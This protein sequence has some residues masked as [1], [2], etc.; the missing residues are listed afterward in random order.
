VVSGHP[1]CSA[2][3]EHGVTGIVL[4]V[5]PSVVEIATAVEALASD[6]AKAHAM[7]AAARDRISTTFSLDVV[8]TRLLQWKAVGAVRS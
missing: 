8:L 7:G 4:G 3:I 2:V 6:A 1:G 5:E